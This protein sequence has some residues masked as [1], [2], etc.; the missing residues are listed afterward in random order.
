MARHGWIATARFRADSR[1]RRRDGARVLTPDE[2][3]NEQVLQDMRD[4]GDDLSMVRPVHFQ[5]VFASEEEARAFATDAAARGFLAEVSELD[6][7]PA[8]DLPWDVNVTL[9]LRPDLRS[10]SDHEHGLGQLA[11]AH[12]GRGDGWF[13]ERITQGEA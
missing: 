6:D 9:E 7:G 5:F 10:I 4:A 11:A 8:P 2:E 12:H 13:C 3:L 1:R